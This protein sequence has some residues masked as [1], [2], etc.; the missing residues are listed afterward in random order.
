M[1]HMRRTLL[2]LLLATAHEYAKQKAA[3]QS[4]N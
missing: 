2:A 4:E 1:T 3:L